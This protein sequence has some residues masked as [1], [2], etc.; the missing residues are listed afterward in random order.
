MCQLHT[1]ADIE[2]ATCL[3]LE[4]ETYSMNIGGDS[5]IVQK[6]LQV[7]L[8]LQ[9][10][11]LC[12]KQSEFWLPALCDVFDEV[13]VDIPDLSPILSDRQYYHVDHDE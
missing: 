12:R 9:W 7:I 5:K 13:Q 10:A 4:T 11:S 8:T 1:F 6:L 3:S 2:L